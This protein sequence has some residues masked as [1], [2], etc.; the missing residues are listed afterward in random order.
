MWLW[1]M[2]TVEPRSQLTG[3]FDYPFFF[4]DPVI[5]LSI[6]NMWYSKIEAIKK[7]TNPSKRVFKTLF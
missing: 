1:K 5:V 7:F 2:N 3:L 6:H 4:P